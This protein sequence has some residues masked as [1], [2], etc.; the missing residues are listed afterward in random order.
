MN[1]R[2]YP[3]QI[4]LALLQTTP[5]ANQRENLQHA[6]ELIEQAAANGANIVCLPELFTIRYPCQSEDHRNFALAEAVPGPTTKRL[7]EV[8]GRHQ[9]VIIGSVFERRD[10]GLYHNTAVV[11]D[12]DGRLLGIYRKM[13]IPDDPFYYEKFYFAP[14]DLGFRVFPT[15]FGRVGVCVC[16]DQWFPEAAR[17]LALRGAELIVYPT[18]IGWLANEKEQFGSTQYSGW[19]TVIRSHAITNGLFVAAVNRAGVEG[20]IEFWG[21]SFVCDPTGNVLARADHRGEQVVS[22]ACNYEQIDAVRTHWPF[23]RD[24]RIDAYEGL[25]ERYLDPQ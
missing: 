13:H 5:G 17:L 2:E 19:E 9:V 6:V 22:A 4:T 7:C 16:W 15:Q 18:A 12:A 10:A 24:R 14:G 3:S 21:G 11:I 1:R 8:A 23:L 25:L 20:N